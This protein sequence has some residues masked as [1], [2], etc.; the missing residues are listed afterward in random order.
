M[1][2]VGEIRFVCWVNPVSAIEADARAE[3]WDGTN[4]NAQDYTDVLGHTAG[5]SF[6]SL[7]DAARW[8]RRYVAAG[9][10][11]FGAGRIDEQV[12]GPDEEIPELGN[13]W[14]N[15]RRWWEVTGDEELTEGE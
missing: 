15:T 5:K 13:T 8:G 9:K 2:L 1:P 11:Y 10:D 14:N 4:G 12:Y 6:A 3:G 7:D